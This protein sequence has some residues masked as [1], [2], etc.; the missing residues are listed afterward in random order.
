MAGVGRAGNVLAIHSDTEAEIFAHRDIGIVGDW[1]E[2]VP[3]LTAESD[4]SGSMVLRRDE[5]RASL[6][7]TR[8]S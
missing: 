1:R 7:S 5:V 8:I 6:T 4:V 2:V 3:L